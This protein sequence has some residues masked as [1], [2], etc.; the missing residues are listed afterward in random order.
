MV[1]V[2]PCLFS[3]QIKLICIYC[4]LSQ[5]HFGI[6]VM[7]SVGKIGFMQNADRFRRLKINEFRRML[8]TVKIANATIDGKNNY[9]DVCR[10]RRH[11][12]IS[13]D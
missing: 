1:S 2:S 13:P 9:T 7:Q 6:D 12:K 3:S 11:R 8:T 5:T 4:E 10:R